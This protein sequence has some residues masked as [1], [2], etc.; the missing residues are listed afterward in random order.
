MKERLWRAGRHLG[1]QGER[2]G[3]PLR[4]RST[5][6]RQ[7]SHDRIHCRVLTCYHPSQALLGGACLHYSGSRR[8]YMFMQLKHLNSFISRAEQSTCAVK[9]CISIAWFAS[10]SIELPVCFSQ[11]P[12]SLPAPLRYFLPSDIFSGF[13][14]FS[15]HQHIQPD[16]H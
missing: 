6:L 5:H 3:S 8:E 15:C 13:S 14:L 11:L 10:A 12:P 2:E 7:M 4:E 16:W 9:S 1:L